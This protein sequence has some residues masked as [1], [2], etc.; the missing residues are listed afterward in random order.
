M[1]EVLGK[2]LCELCKAKIEN[3]TYK[4]NI[5]L[6][7]RMKPCR[8]PFP[9]I[10][11]PQK[12]QKVTPTTSPNSPKTKNQRKTHPKTRNFAKKTNKERK[13]RYNIR[14]NI[15]KKKKNLEPTINQNPLKKKSEPPAPHPTPPK[16][17]P[18][19]SS[20]FAHQS[21]SAPGAV[22][23]SPW[24]RS[25]R[26]AALRC[27]LTR[28]GF[29][30]RLGFFGVFLGGGRKTPVFFWFFGGVFFGGIFW[31]FWGSV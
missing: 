31:F 16:T 25:S 23:R 27:S 9:N 2:G 18:S 22:G 10:Q 3:N 4:S 21:P 20:A 11:S 8:K 14:Y 7:S 28:P 26:A 15:K 17:P 30:V 12:P 13:N 6:E 19:L 1:K 5:R 29:G 24:P